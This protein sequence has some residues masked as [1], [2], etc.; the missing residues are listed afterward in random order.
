MKRFLLEHRPIPMLVID[1]ER[2]TAASENNGTENRAV[3][4]ARSIGYERAGSTDGSPKR[5]VVKDERCSPMLT[6]L[7][8]G[9]LG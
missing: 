4:A 2:L 8:P 5:I 9:V 6:P 1:N 3:Y 7:P